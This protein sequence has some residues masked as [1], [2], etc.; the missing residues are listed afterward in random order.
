MLRYVI[1]WG[2][3]VF[4]PS[5]NIVSSS[6]E[7]WENL[8]TV[9]YTRKSELSLEQQPISCKNILS[10]VRLQSKYQVYS[11]RP[12]LTLSVFSSSFAC[13][14]SDKPL[15]NICFA[16]ATFPESAKA[17]PRKIKAKSS[18]GSR[19]NNFVAHSMTFSLSLNA[20][21]NS[22]MLRSKSLKK[23]QERNEKLVIA[24]W[25]LRAGCCGLAIAGW[26]LRPGYCGLAIAGWLLRV[27]YCGLA[28]AG[29]LFENVSF[30]WLKAVFL[31]LYG[32]QGK[33]HARFMKTF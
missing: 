25:L 31:K 10:E 23:K 2:G 3:G 4:I 27:G 28:I 24:G 7:C 20:S 17:R 12:P 11:S 5:M 32:K 21:D 13:C 14:A 22:T 30:N 1:F 16:S 18:D 15:L 8:N 19:F 6:N 26:L 33:V 9:S 29:W